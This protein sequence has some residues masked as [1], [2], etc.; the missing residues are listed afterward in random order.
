MDHLDVVQQTTVEKKML[1]YLIEGLRQTM[2]WTVQGDD[3]KR[4]LSTLRFIARSFHNHMERLMHLEEKD[5]YMDIV[6][7]S[8]PQLDKAVTALR[9]EHDEIRASLKGVSEGLEKIGPRDTVALTV[10]CEELATLLKKVD[11]HHRKECD[12]FQE[13]FERE[14]GGEG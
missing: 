6:L 5:G 9:Q 3:L 7:E 1:A 2:A 14:D 4:K 8:H 13:A 12:L 11:E 10:L